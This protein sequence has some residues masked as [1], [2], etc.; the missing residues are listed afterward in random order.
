M[1]HLHPNKKAI[2]KTF[3]SSFFAKEKLQMRVTRLHEQSVKLK[4]VRQRRA[5]RSR[6]VRALQAAR[7]W[8]GGP[9]SRAVSSNLCL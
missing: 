3:G 9:V 6:H 2:Q 4:F 1:L 8:R 7:R 5:K